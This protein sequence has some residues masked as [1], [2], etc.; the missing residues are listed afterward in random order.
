MRGE[1]FGQVPRTLCATFADGR[2]AG[3]SIINEAAAASPK[4]PI[5][6]MGQGF[7]GYNPPPFIINAAKDALDRVDCN[8]Y[9]PTKGRPRLKKAI[10]DAYAPFWGRNLDPETEVTITTGAN[11]GEFWTRSASSV[12]IGD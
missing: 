3:R 4:Q 7:F 9:S 12:K 1:W 11:E 2:P 8:Q 5:V 10:A 6:N